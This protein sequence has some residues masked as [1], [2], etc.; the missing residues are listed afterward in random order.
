MSSLAINVPSGTT[1]LPSNVKFQGSGKD[2]VIQKVKRRTK[3]FKMSKAQRNK[4]S[5][6]ARKFKVP[7]LTAVSVAPAVLMSAQT[8]LVQPTPMAKFSD[9]ARNMISFYTGIWIN[10]LGQVTFQPQRLLVGWAPIVAV[11]AV[12]AL[13]RGRV[14]AINRALSRAQIPANLS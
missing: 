4:I 2:L 9:F 3:K 8:A 13:A 1:V 10:R 14:M 7:I 12:K 6:A 11:G 5:A